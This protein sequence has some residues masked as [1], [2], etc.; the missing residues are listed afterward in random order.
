MLIVGLTGGIASGK[1]TVSR[2][3]E[4]A[5][6]P[7]I[8]SDELAREVVRPDSPGLAEIRRIFGEDVLDGEGKLDREAMARLVFQ[9]RSKRKILESIIHPR[10]AEEQNKRLRTLEGQGHSIV[11]V[12]VP[13]L[14]ETGW[15]QFVDL[16][17]VVYVPRG[18]QEE[19]LVKRDGMSVDDARSRLDAQMPIDEKR[20]LADRLVDNGNTL[21]HTRR[22]VETLVEEL[23]EAAGSKRATG[24]GIEE[25]PGPDSRRQILD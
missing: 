8:C 10:V 20:R 9:D 11:I 1:S 16:V 3:F 14:Y 4:Q 25:R 22:Q 19:R 6:I 13:L 7:V 21:E 17:V 5:G 24:S 12:D 18:M 23:K 15:E 2:M